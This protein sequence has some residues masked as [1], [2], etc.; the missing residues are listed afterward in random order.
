MG[1]NRITVMG[2]LTKDPELRHTSSGIA[3]AS[4]TLAVDRDYGAKDDGSREADFPDVVAWRSTAEFAS[5]YLAKGRMVAVDGRLQTRMY[6][7]KEGKKRKAVEIVADRIYF[8]DSKRTDDSGTQTAAYQPE[9]PSG[10]AEINE[11]DDE[12][13]F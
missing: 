2:R 10:F 1:M 5:K 3:C 13:P 9:E 11:P 4:F 6:E 8:A 7:D 12:L